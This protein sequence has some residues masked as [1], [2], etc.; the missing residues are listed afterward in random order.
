M[1][2]IP[3]IAFSGSSLGIKMFPSL[4]TCGKLW[5]LP[6]D[7]SFETS[8]ANVCDTQNDSCTVTLHWF[9]K[10]IFSF[11]TMITEYL[12]E[13]STF[14]IFPSHSMQIYNFIWCVASHH[15][16]TTPIHPWCRIQAKVCIQWNV[17]GD[18]HIFI[19]TIDYVKKVV[20]VNMANYPSEF[21]RYSIFPDIYIILHR[22]ITYVTN[23]LLTQIVLKVRQHGIPSANLQNYKSSLVGLIS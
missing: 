21:S 7:V 11:I 8:L 19:S 23:Q 3:P 9:H 5:W 22:P 13:I 10:N 16:T 12:L 2:P 17:V 1:L 15:P 20:S 6:C 18:S 14:I 4:V